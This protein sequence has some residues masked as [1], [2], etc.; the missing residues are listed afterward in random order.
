MHIDKNPSIVMLI[1]GM[2]RLFPE[3]KL[4][5]AM[6]DP[7]DV[8]VSCFMRYLPL[9]TVSVH[10][11]TLEDAARRNRRDMQAWFRLREMIGSPWLEI[12]YEDTV[13][14]LQQEARRAL[15]FLDVPWSP[16]VMKY[17]EQLQQRQVN[18]PTYEDVAKPVYK[19]AVGRWKNYERHLGPALS[20]LEPLLRQLDYTS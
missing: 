20:V 3:C 11:L 17:R 19:S 16:Q 8:V 1:P 10:F 14:N 6:R 12:R 5:I 13:K 9:N 7:R 18:S 2:L 4:L 15:E